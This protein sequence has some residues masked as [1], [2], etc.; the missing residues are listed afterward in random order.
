MTV[1][2]QDEPAGRSTIG[3]SV[4]TVGP[5]LSVNAWLPTTEHVMANADDGA[6]TGSLKVTVTFAPPP[7]SVAPFA[8]VVAR[9]DGA[10]SAVVPVT[11][12]LS[13]PIHSSEPTASVVIQRTCTIGWPAAAAG[14]GTLTKVTRSA[15]LGVEASATKAAGTFV[16]AP[17]VPIRYW[18]ATGWTALS[19]PPS[20]SRRSYSTRTVETPV[21]LSVRTMCGARAVPEPWNATTGFVSSNSAIPPV[22]RPA[23]FVWLAITS[24]GVP[25]PSARTVCGSTAVEL[26]RPSP[27]YATMPGTFVH[28]SSRV[29]SEMS[30]HCCVN[31]SA[32]AVVSAA[33]V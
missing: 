14:S 32:W 1:T 26:V 18:S 2:V 29:I 24:R 7:T 23:G 15:A 33:A 17:V 6:E 27:R 16:Y 31:G 25:L 3:S 11:L 28:V 9:T 12:M 22:A 10:A 13:T 8:G 19:A 21:V 5:P 4:K 20:T 30:V